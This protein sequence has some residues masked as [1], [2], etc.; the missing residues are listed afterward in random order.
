MI[1]KVYFTVRILSQ[2]AGC[3]WACVKLLWAVTFSKGGPIGDKC[4]L[5]FQSW[6]GESLGAEPPLKARDKGAH[7][8]RPPG[9]ALRVESQVKR[10]WKAKRSRLGSLEKG[11]WVS[12]LSSV[13]WWLQKRAFICFAHPVA[14][15][16]RFCCFLYSPQKTDKD[17]GRVLLRDKLRS[18]PYPT[19]L[20]PSLRRGI[21]SRMFK[22]TTRLHP[23]THLG[24]LRS[25]CMGRKRSRFLFE[26]KV[27]NIQATLPC[28]SVLETKGSWETRK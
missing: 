27:F 12:F 19:F 18:S 16:N 6:A 21:R 25:E 11:K 28:M 15:A 5:S 24:L 10:M 26:L 23:Q 13:L 22:I 2:E 9:P 7:Y 4:P 8:F 14:W 17:S 20:H 1:M 3:E